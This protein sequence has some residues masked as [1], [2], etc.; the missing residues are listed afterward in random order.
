MNEDARRQLLLTQLDSKRA[1]KE[2][3]LHSGSDPVSSPLT[4]LVLSNALLLAVPRRVDLFGF[5][6]QLRMTWESSG[7]DLL[8]AA[9]DW[10]S[11]LAEALDCSAY[12]LFLDDS[13][14]RRKLLCRMLQKLSDC[15]CF[16]NFQS[17]PQG[18]SFVLPGFDYVFGMTE[19]PSATLFFE[20]ST[21]P[22]LTYTLSASDGR[23]SMGLIPSK[24]VL[25]TESQGPLGSFMEAALAPDSVSRFSGG[26]RLGEISQLISES[27]ELFRDLIPILQEAPGR[28]TPAPILAKQLSK[29]EPLR[30]EMV[31]LY[32]TMPEQLK[33]GTQE[34]QFKDALILFAGACRSLSRMTEAPSEAT[35][36]QLS[37]LVY[38]LDHTAQSVYS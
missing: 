16:E 13:S 4:E 19:R 32:D 21:Q 11:Q 37:D 7:Q 31:S 24:I 8:D 20:K 38:L 28:I 35:P 26:D 22:R 27:A 30:Q 1:M 6:R 9:M 14:K 12:E 10:I 29:L 33:A 25:W 3:Y 34:Q 17:T 2:K 15:P 5:L 23:R 36:D 18:E